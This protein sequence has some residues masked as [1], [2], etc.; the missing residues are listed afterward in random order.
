MPSCT[1]ACSSTPGPTTRPGLGGAGRLPLDLLA[2]DGTAV[3]LDP[4]LLDDE[5][6]PVPAD[7]VDELACVAR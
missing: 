5:P 2:A 7:L 4:T 6:P 3:E 1:T